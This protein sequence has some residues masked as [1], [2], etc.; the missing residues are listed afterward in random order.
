V[1]IRA[2]G[3]AAVGGRTGT[4]IAGT[5][6]MVAL[7]GMLTPLFFPVLTAEDAVCTHAVQLLGIINITRFP[8]LKD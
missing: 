4:G 8:V 1:E 2:D 5:A 7:D 3:A 6:A